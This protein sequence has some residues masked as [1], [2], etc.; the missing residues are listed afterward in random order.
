MASK[1]TLHKV[2]DGELYVA[3]KVDAEG[4]GT[5]IF[6]FRKKKNGAVYAKVYNTRDLVGPN[7][8]VPMLKHKASF[9]PKKVSSSDKSVDVRFSE[10]VAGK[11]YKFALVMTRV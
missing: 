4:Q 3:R 5:V 10:K 6:G 2:K 7:D 9:K 1:A 11:K 8:L